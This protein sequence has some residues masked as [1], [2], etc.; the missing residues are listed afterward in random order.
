MYCLVGSRSAAIAALV[1]LT[2]G[3]SADDPVHPTVSAATRASQEVQMVAPDGR[4]KTLDE[5]FVEIAQSV[6]GF[7]GIYVLPDGT[8]EALLVDLNRS[9]H[10]RAALEQLLERSIGQGNAHKPLKF[11]RAQYDFLQLY[12]WKLELTQTLLTD[13][14]VVGLD[15]DEVRNRI[16]VEVLTQPAVGRA[17]A[18]LARGEI[19]SDVTVV[20]PDD[21]SEDPPPDGFVDDASEGSDDASYT[22]IDGPTIRDF[23]SSVPGGVQILNSTNSGTCTSGFNTYLSSTV[24]GIYSGNK[25]LVTAAHC[26]T[27]LGAVD[28]AFFYQPRYGDG[29]RLIGNE[30]REPLWHTYSPTT[31]LTC[32]P[33]GILCSTADAA[34]I[35]YAGF[36]QPEARSIAR[37]T[38]LGSITLQPGAPRWKI[39]DSLENHGLLAGAVVTK[40]GVTTGWQWGTITQ[41]CKQSRLF[42][43]GALTNYMVTCAWAFD[44]D[45]AGG[46]SGGPVFV[47]KYY[48]SS[49]VTLVGIVSAGTIGRSVFSFYPYIAYELTHRDKAFACAGVDLCWPRLTVSAH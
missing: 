5:V 13:P 16:T 9:E 27:T 40:M 44:G 32:P 46:D 38:T 23:F 12:R 19:P 11:R 33:G 18:L 28:G 8:P 7:A 29:T 35:Q 30:V 43:R 48:N 26:T 20:D 17:R 2:T 22:G 39:V 6:P 15:I 10:A 47:N 25:Y 45:A 21:G 41:T 49:E 31:D 4:P 34:L 14:E 37:T 1:F 3:C 24:R 36:L 42:H